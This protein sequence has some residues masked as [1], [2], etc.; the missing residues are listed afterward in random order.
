MLIIVL[1]T[2]GRLYVRRKTSLRGDDI[3]VL[4][5]VVMM[6][7]H[8]AVT[9]RMEFAKPDGRES[10]PGKFQRNDANER[11]HSDKRIHCV[12]LHVCHCSVRTGLVS[13]SWFV[14]RSVVHS[15]ITVSGRDAY[16]CSSPS[17]HSRPPPILELASHSIPLL[18][19]SPSSSSSRAAHIPRSLARVSPTQQS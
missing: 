5:G 16:L 13:I 11:L 10:F 19:P 15:R 1:T 8:Q 4:V 17:C 7:L 9:W 3:C 2:V 6:A 18:G 14:C 12:V